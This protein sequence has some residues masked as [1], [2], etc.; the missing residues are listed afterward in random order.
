L[1][2]PVAV[3]SGCTKLTPKG[4]APEGLRSRSRIEVGQLLGHFRP[5]AVIDVLVAGD[6]LEILRTSRGASSTPEL[7]SQRFGS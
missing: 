7:A 1:C 4:D 5:K 6:D 2:V 3:L